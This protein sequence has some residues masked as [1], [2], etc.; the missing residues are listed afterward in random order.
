MRVPSALCGCVFPCVFSVGPRCRWGSPGVCVITP[1]PVCSLPPAAEPGPQ[2]GISQRAITPEPQFG[3]AEL[4]VSMSRS[5]VFRGFRENFPII[6]A[7]LG[8]ARLGSVRGRFIM[9]SLSS[10]IKATLQSP[11]Y[12]HLSPLRVLIFF[13]FLEGSYRPLACAHAWNSIFNSRYFKVSFLKTKTSVSLTILIVFFSFYQ[14][15]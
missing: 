8:S 1:R 7:R 13:F 2:P 14:Q 9:T 5:C 11:L 6:S 15:F 3:A 12:I 10:L 4:L